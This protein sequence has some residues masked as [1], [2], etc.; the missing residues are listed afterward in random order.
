LLL[1]DALTNIGEDALAT[2]IAARFCALVEHGG[3]AENFNALTGAP[4]RDR[5]H[6][7]SASVFVILAHEYLR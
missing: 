3:M 2:T 6:T 5:A 4:L 7:W 1:V